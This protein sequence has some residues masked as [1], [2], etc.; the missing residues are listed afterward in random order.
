MWLYVNV[1]CLNVCVLACFCVQMCVFI[2]LWS[3]ACAHLQ[4]LVTCL[5]S[6]PHGHLRMLTCVC[7]HMC[8]CVFI[9]MHVCSIDF[10]TQVL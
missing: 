10:M 8:A 1:L 6:S 5:A 3:C 7:V 2:Y 9:S 4:N